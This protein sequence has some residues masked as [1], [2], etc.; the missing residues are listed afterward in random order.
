MHP[1]PGAKF[2]FPPEKHFLHPVQGLV[3]LVWVIL[4]DNQLSVEAEAGSFSWSSLFFL[5]LFYPSP[6]SNWCSLS[7]ASSLRY[8]QCPYSLTSWQGPV[9]PPVAHTSNDPLHPVSPFETCWPALQG[10]SPHPSWTSSKIRTLSCGISEPFFFLFGTRL[11]FF[12]FFM[13]TVIHEFCNCFGSQLDWFPGGS[14]PGH[15]NIM[16]GDGAE[17]QNNTTKGSSHMLPMANCKGAVK[18]SKLEAHKSLRIKPS[19]HMSTQTNKQSP[20]LAASEQACTDFPPCTL[21]CQHFMHCPN[22]HFLFFSSST[23]TFFSFPFPQ[24][25]SFLSISTE[26]LFRALCCVQ[27]AHPTCVLIVLC[28]FGGYLCPCKNS[29]R[30]TADMAW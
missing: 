28:Y 20:K 2:V 17:H 13:G 16:A 27:L 1:Q 6:T 19:L 7:T 5:F 12:F 9:W 25:L 30:S 18:Q 3:I 29:L 11:V 4:P 23:K 14:P 24:K 8:W 22:K 26:P 21:N 10:H 15:I